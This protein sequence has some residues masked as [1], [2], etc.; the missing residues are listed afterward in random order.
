LGLLRVNELEEIVG[1]DATYSVPSPAH[2]EEESSS[3]EELRL[4]A[5]KQR[6][7]EKKKLRQFKSFQ[8]MSLNDLLSECF[9]GSNA[10]LAAETAF[11]T[12]SNDGSMVQRNRTIPQES[13]PFDPS[14]AAM[15][16][17]DR[18]G[19]GFNSTV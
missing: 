10:K 13:A 4:A 7:E 15:V 1:L 12:A 6:F 11:D 2:F 9:F 5:Y 18:N 16:M 14:D 8:E 3:N 17:M 19:R